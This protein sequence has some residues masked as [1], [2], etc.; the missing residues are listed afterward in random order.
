M[1]SFAVLDSPRFSVVTFRA[2]GKTGGDAL[3]KAL[4]ALNDAGDV[5]VDRAGCVSI[6][7]VP[8][9]K[10]DEKGFGKILS[11]AGVEADGL[12]TADIPLEL[13]PYR[14]ELS[15]VSD[16]TKALAVRE[17]L[18]SIRQVAVAQVFGDAAVIFLREPCAKIEEHV[19]GALGKAGVDVGKIS[20]G[21]PVAAAK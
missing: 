14:I 4:S 2:T 16:Q 15:G 21:E 9:A 11:D 1:A 5:V 12:V 3:A 17:A 19:G 18:L 7:L 6:S 13:V 20:M 8:G 10:L